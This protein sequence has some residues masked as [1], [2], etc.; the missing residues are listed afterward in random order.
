MDLVAHAEQNAAAAKQLA[1]IYAALYKGL[2]EN[3][4]PE[5]VAA[6]LTVTYVR[7]STTNAR[8]DG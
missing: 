6:Q 7:M 5:D 1:R 8:G 4:L 3:G 2:I